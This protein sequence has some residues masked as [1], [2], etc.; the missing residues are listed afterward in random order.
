MKD[1]QLLQILAVEEVL[2][3]VFEAIRLVVKAL[4]YVNAQITARADAIMYLIR[5][6]VL[7]LV[8]YQQFSLNY[9]SQIAAKMV[10]EKEGQKIPL[11]F[12]TKN[13]GQWLENIVDSGCDAV[14]LDWTTDIGQ[15]RSR[16]GD[17]VALQGN[18]DPAIL[19]SN[20]KIVSA[21][22]AMF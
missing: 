2:S 1:I 9:L 17:R 20:P 21:A 6:A 11:I 3:Y 5:G 12:F 13:G 16:V 14:I 22:T 18:L 19:L 4:N 10:R 7:S 8:A 15:A